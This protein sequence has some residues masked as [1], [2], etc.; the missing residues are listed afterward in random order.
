MVLIQVKH[1]EALSLPVLFRLVLKSIYDRKNFT[2][3]EGVKMMDS[4]L[5]W[6]DHI[7][8]REDMGMD[9]VDRE[10][11]YRLGIIAMLLKEDEEGKFEGRKQTFQDK[12]INYKKFYGLPEAYVPEDFVKGQQ[13]LEEHKRTNPED[14]ET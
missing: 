10:N 12:G 5:N 11:Q 2:A 1:K 7:E 3:S 8:I 6:K 14:Y 13:A 9:A 4:V